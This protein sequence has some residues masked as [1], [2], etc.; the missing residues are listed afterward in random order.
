LKAGSR[1]L[2]NVRYEHRMKRK[3]YAREAY[4]SNTELL[5]KTFQRD[6]RWKMENKGE[7]QF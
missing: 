3:V 5:R 1:F 2:E 6:L 7:D 4:D